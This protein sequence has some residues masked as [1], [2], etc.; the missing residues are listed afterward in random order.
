M[1]LSG[2]LVTAQ[3]AGGGNGAGGLGVSG[4]RGEG[5]REQGEELS[6][7]TS[8]CQLM[9]YLCTPEIR[10]HCCTLKYCAKPN[11]STAVRTGNKKMKILI[12]TRIMQP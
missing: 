3:E 4:G 10:F 1:D 6:N 7:L 2:H 9:L 12:I 11:T 5:G 8:I